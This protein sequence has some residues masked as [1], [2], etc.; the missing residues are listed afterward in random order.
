MSA[1]LCHLGWANQMA[2]RSNV[3]HAR[4]VEPTKCQYHILT[5]LIATHRELYDFARYTA[6]V[7]TS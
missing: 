7:L 1:K 4:D 5:E 2:T 6:F 3:G